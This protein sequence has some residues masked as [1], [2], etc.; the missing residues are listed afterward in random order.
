MIA[1]ILISSS[2]QKKKKNKIYV[3]QKN[4]KKSTKNSIKKISIKLKIINKKQKQNIYNP[5]KYQEK[6]QK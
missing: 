2:N 4:T 3:I 5:E 1:K 6:Y